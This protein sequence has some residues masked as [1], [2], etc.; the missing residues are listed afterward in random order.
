M[1]GSNIFKDGQDAEL[2]PDSEYP[3]W[4]WTLHEPLP[5]LQTLTAR[6]QADPESLGPEDKKRLYKLWNKG[7]I[8][9]RN[10]ETAK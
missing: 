7:R 5:T 1:T 9:E 10:A 4:V 3:E 8:K 6:Y 2:L